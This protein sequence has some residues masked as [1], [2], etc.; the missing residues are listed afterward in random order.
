MTKCPHCT[1]YP[2]P[3]Y[4]WNAKPRCTI[5]AYI[6]IAYIVMAYIAIAKIVMAY[7]AIAY[8]VMAYIAIAY[9]VMAYRC[10]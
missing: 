8:I 7:I 5:R 6:A 10:R 2:L 3:P 9:I 1:K 4:P